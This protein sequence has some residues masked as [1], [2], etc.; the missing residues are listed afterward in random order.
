MTRSLLALL[1]LALVLVAAA[2]ES[3]LAAHPDAFADS[4]GAWPAAAAAHRPGR[5][6]LDFA[7]GPN[8]R[9]GS[10]KGTSLSATRTTSLASAWRFGIG[11]AISSRHDVRDDVISPDS[12]ATARNHGDFA[13]DRLSLTGVVMRLRRF[14]PARR[15]GAYWGLGPSVGWDRSHD[16]NVISPDPSIPFQVEN[17]YFHQVT[18]GLDLDVGAEAFVARSISLFGQYESSGGYRFSR[19]VERFQLFDV[20]TGKPVTLLDQRTDRTHEWFLNPGG[21]SLGISIYL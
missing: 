12:A 18:L 13:G 5:W 19:D 2:P 17:H 4:S 15:I 21:V 3:A 14:Q 6:S 11:Y 8:F 10:F 9:L 20:A 16:E 1:G 7:V